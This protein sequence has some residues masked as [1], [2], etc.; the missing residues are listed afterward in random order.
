MLSNKEKYKKFC[1]INNDVPLFMTYNWYNFLFNDVDWNV[2]LIEKGEEL[3]GFL[4][5]ILS[6]KKTFNVINQPLLT[7]YQGVWLNYPKD[8]KYANKLGFEKEVITDLIK[9]LPKTDLFQQK[10]SPQFTN[11]LPFYWKGFEQTTRYT[12]IINDLSSLS[13]VFSN[14]KENIRREIRKAEKKLTISTI[15]DVELL[16]Q[17]KNEIYTA[18]K[19]T[20]PISLDLLTMVYEFCKVNNSGEILTA[21]DEEDNIHSILFYVWDNS[22]A[23]YLQGVTADKFKTTGSMSLLL[24][25]AISRSASKSKT[26]NFEGSMIESIE[27]YFRAFGG[28]QTPYFEIKKTSSKFLKLLNY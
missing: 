21:K 26:F 22:S 24:W 12:Y 7:P 25:E 9:Q 14:F 28:V 5:Y 27:R 13:D 16:Y 3:V 11:W 17:M 23:Y 6:K 19:S 10:F 4:P 18:N 1:E 8:Q 15:T 20:Y 2:V